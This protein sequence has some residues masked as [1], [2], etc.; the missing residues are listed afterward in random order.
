MQCY[1]ETGGEAALVCVQSNLVE[2]APRNAE[3]DDAFLDHFAQLRMVLVVL[4]E[5]VFG[6][7]ETAECPGC[8]QH[9]EIVV[10]MVV[11]HRH[12]AELFEVLQLLR[13]STRKLNVT[14]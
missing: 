3:S 12:Y 9:Y 8:L 7:H 14:K 6:N 13:V 10:R 5:L 2:R 4:R 11:Y 1:V